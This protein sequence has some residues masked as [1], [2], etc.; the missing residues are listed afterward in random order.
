MADARL[1]FR[2]LF[3]K[4]WALTLRASPASLPTGVYHG[5][6]SVLMRTRDLVYSFSI[7]VDLTVTPGTPVGT[8]RRRILLACPT[9]QTRDRPMEW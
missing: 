6:V 2:C 3:G 1:R 5:G 9:H 8:P 7:P 4:H